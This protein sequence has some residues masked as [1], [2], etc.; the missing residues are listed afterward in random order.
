MAQNGRNVF[1]GGKGAVK[2]W[3][4]GDRLGLLPSS[5]ANSAV[6]ALS[7]AS[8]TAAASDDPLA[9]VGTFQCLKDSYIRSCKLF[10]DAS[11]LIVGGETKTIC[12]W[13]LNSEKVLYCRILLFFFF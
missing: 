10:P 3:D 8:S 5:A 13:D 9:P 2:M 4:V 7:P 11:T 12:V 6:G 1:T